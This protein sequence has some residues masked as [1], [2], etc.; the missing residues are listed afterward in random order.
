MWGPHE[1][2]QRPTQPSTL[3]LAG[4]SCFIGTPM[5]HQDARHQAPQGTFPSCPQNFVVLF[6]FR[7]L[8]CLKN[9]FTLLTLEN[10]PEKCCLLPPTDVLLGGVSQV[11]YAVWSMVSA[12]VGTVPLFHEGQCFPVSRAF[13]QLPPFRKRWSKIKQPPL[14][15]SYLPCGLVPRPLASCSYCCGTTVVGG[16]KG[17]GRYLIIEGKDRLFYIGCLIPQCIICT[18]KDSI[19]GFVFLLHFE[20]VG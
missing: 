3:P 18:R 4:I 1:A 5:K 7:P 12:S 6:P 20:L 14:C 9:I 17:G 11:A 2:D 15:Q 19:P 13:S 8:I 10:V 16:R